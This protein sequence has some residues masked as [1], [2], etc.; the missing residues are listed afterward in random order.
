LRWQ[1]VS[2]EQDTRTSPEQG[3]GLGFTAV[4]ERNRK[5]RADRICNF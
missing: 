3:E 2:T 4:I 1:L 5:V